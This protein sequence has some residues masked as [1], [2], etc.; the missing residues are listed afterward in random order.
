MSEGVDSDVATLDNGDCKQSLLGPSTIREY[1]N[2]VVSA[3]VDLN[4]KYAEWKP[5]FEEA[6]DEI[7]RV[8]EELT[9]TQKGVNITRTFSSSFSLVAGTGLGVLA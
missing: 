7:Q 8:V 9:K 1:R 5:V 2:M 6:I 4:C 3:L